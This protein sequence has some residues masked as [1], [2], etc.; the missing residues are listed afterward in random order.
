MSQQL[1]NHY[2]ITQPIDL[3]IKKKKKRH[4]SFWCLYVTSI[5]RLGSTAGFGSFRHACHVWWNPRGKLAGFCVLR[6]WKALGVLCRQGQRGSSE[7]HV[8]SQRR[9]PNQQMK[10][11]LQGLWRETIRTKSH[12]K[13]AQ[14]DS[15]CYL[16]PIC[17]LLIL[18]SNKTLF[19]ASIWTTK[20][21]KSQFLLIPNLPH[22]TSRDP[23]ERRL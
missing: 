11:W 17:I 13:R 8:W 19:L 7:P 20:K 12:K 9:E 21:S 5:Q 23:T 22:V 3:F 2:P 10:C 4:F 15:L 1:I 16:I 14:S 6:H 18:L